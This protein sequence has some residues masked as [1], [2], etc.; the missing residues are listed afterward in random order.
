M[1][2]GGCSVRKR[3]VEIQRVKDA[4]NITYA[5]AVRRVKEAGTRERVVE[6]QQ[7]LV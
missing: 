3:A 5:E 2:Y 7:L 4:S 6:D 1:A